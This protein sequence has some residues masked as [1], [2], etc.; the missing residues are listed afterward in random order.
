MVN[1][2]ENLVNIVCE[3]PKGQF[4]TMVLAALV[5][6][7]LGESKLGHRFELCVSLDYIWNK[8]KWGDKQRANISNWGDKHKRQINPGGVTNIKDRQT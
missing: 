4:K 2:G 5:Q 6:S 8:S 7:A 1:N 3:Y